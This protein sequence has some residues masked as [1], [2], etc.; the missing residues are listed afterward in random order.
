M[1]YFYEEKT[2]NKSRY[3]WPNGHLKKELYVCANI[4]KKIWKNMHQ[5][6]Y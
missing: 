5:K 3:K 1:I 4:E 2:S 6:V